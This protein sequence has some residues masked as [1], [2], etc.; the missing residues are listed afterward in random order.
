MVAI[1]ARP[2]VNEENIPY[3]FI[4]LRCVETQSHATSDLTPQG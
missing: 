4:D 1:I 2:Q 3:D